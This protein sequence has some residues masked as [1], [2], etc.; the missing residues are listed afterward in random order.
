MCDVWYWHQVF[1]FCFPVQPSSRRE[2]W[3]WM[4]SSRSWCL[5]HISANSEYFH[6]K[7]VPQEGKYVRIG[8]KSGLL[9]FNMILYRN[10][11][12][13]LKKRYKINNGA[14]MRT[15]KWPTWSCLFKHLISQPRLLKNGCLLRGNSWYYSHYGI[16]LNRKNITQCDMISS[17]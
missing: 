11:L 1:P 9:S 6:S 3:G 5:P 13:V 4:T 14:R 8:R 12:D 10:I 2:K 15:C 7:Y 17:G 16:L